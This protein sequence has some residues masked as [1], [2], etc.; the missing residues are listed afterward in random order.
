MLAM[1]IAG[2]AFL[3]V[4]LVVAAVMTSGGQED[5]QQDDSPFVPPSAVSLDE[6]DRLDQVVDRFVAPE[7]PDSI[8]ELRRLLAQA[9]YRGR[10]ALTVLL[11]SQLCLAIALPIPIS[12]ALGLQA[13]A[14]GAAIVLLT[15]GLGYGLPLLLVRLARAD[16]Q[17]ELSNAVPNMMDMLVSSLEAGLGIDAAL[18]YAGREISVASPDLGAELAIATAEMT[19]G[20]PRMEA[21]RRLDHRTGVAELSSLINVI[22]QAERYGAGAAQSVRAQAQLSRRRRALDAERRAANASPLLTVAMIV[23]ILPALFIVLLGPSLANLL[24]GRLS[25]VAGG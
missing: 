2:G 10:R 24:T 21:L 8:E 25:F 3:T 20:V 17:K 22:G 18:Q 9:G 7:D 6:P 11:L 15:A 1:I 16:R 13:N 4:L 5:G 19:A 14:R 12:M 23:F